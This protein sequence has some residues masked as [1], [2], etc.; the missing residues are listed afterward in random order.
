M[1]GDSPR[2]QDDNYKH[3]NSVHFVSLIERS[4][5]III[6]LLLALT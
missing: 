1:S 6:Q 2:A 4:T 3:Y 5:I